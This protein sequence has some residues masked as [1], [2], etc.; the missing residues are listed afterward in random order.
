[1]FVPKSS[2][3]VL[4]EPSPIIGSVDAVDAAAEFSA[5]TV[6]DARNFGGLLSTASMHLSASRGAGA[7]EIR[8]RST[9]ELATGARLLATSASASRQGFRAYAS[10]I[11]RIHGVARSLRERVDRALDRIRVQS[12]AIAAIA[13]VVHASPPADW[14][15]PPSMTMPDPMLDQRSAAME[16]DERELMIRHLAQT[17]A[18]RWQAAVI[19]WTQARDDISEHRTRWLSLVEDREHAERALLRSLRETDLGRLIQAAGTGGYS[20]KEM[21]AFGFS[22]ELRGRRPTIG[23]VRNRDVEALL[24]LDGPPGSTADA[25]KE[26]G[27]SREDVAGLPIETLAQLANRDELPV[28]VQDT[29]ATALLHYALIAPDRAYPL[30]E[31]GSSAP[32]MYEFRSQIMGLYGAWRDA[33]SEAEHLGGSPEVQLLALGSHDGALTA[34]LSHG[35]LDTASH[36]GV[37]VSGMFSNVGDI[38]QDAKGARSLYNEAY[39]FD[40]EQT[41]A[42]VTW[43]GYRSPGLMSVNLQGRADAGGAEFAAFIDGIHENRA[44]NGAAIDNFTVFGHSYGSTTAAAALTRTSHRVDSFVTYGSAGLSARH[45]A[46]RINASHLFSTQAAGDQVA[47]HGQNWSHP[48]DPRTYTEVQ[49]FSSR[50]GAGHLRVTAHD[51]FTED[52]SPSVLNWGGK[53]GYLTPGT[54]SART[55]GKIWARGRL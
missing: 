14:Q 43:I 47:R 8:I 46:E 12:A 5:A 17:Y 27:L 40:P 42:A 24:E 33:K 55:M 41:Y 50:G 34:A 22:G 2:E 18:A 38:G 25:W 1:M 36:I 49:E 6:S 11:H 53:V 3:A 7:A 35:D 16:A 21:V 30:F 13:E 29:A 32:D 23:G 44:A 48:V 26:L 20:A 52:D 31:T 4:S 28:W 15:S 39:V 51:M 10:E 19:E 54:E 37:N 45:S 9:S